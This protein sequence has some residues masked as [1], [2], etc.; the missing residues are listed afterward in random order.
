MIRESSVTKLLRD[1]RAEIARPTRPETPRDMRPVGGSARGLLDLV[2][3][4]R[5]GGNNG[6]T[7]SGNGNAGDINI[8]KGAGTVAVTHASGLPLLAPL[9]SARLAPLYSSTDASSLSHAPPPVGNAASAQRRTATANSAHSSAM[10]DGAPTTS[11]MLGAAAAAGAVGATATTTANSNSSAAA[12]ATTFNVR[13]PPTTKPAKPPTQ[14]RTTTAT[15]TAVATVA[16]AGGAPPQSALVTRRRAKMPSSTRSGE[17]S[18]TSSLAGDGDVAPYDD[19]SGNHANGTVG[20]AKRVSSQRASLASNNFNNNNNN[21]NNNNIDDGD[22][23]EDGGTQQQQHQHQPPSAGAVPAEKYKVLIAQMDAADAPTRAR[24][25]AEILAVL[26]QLGTGAGASSCANDDDDEAAFFSADDDVASFDCDKLRTK[27]LEVALELFRDNGLDDDDDDVDDD[28]HH[29][30]RDHDDPDRGG[31]PPRRPGWVAAKEARLIDT[32]LRYIESR[33]VGTV[34]CTVALSCIKSA[35]E[36]RE[37]V[38]SIFS[39]GGIRVM[40]HVL[41]SAVAILTSTSMSAPASQQ[42]QSHSPILILSVAMALQTLGFLSEKYS[43]QIIRGG[44]CAPC[45]H[46]AP[47]VVDDDRAA[48]ALCS[49]VAKLSADDHDAVHAWR[50]C[51]HGAL[52]QRLGRCVL[53][54]WQRVRAGKAK[55]TGCTLVS[56]GMLA[57]A[58]LIADGGTPL[59]QV[60]GD[61]PLLVALCEE[62]DDMACRTNPLAAD[63]NEELVNALRLISGISVNAAGGH[64]LAQHPSL[65]ELISDLL[66]DLEPDSPT[67]QQVLLLSL[68]CVSN[69][70]FYCFQPSLST[71]S[72]SHC[73]A[74]SSGSDN[75]GSGMMGGRRDYATPDDDDEISDSISLLW[76]DTLLPSLLGILFNDASPTEALVEATRALGNVSRTLAGCSACRAHRID[77]VV[78]ALL[79]HADARIVYNCLGVVTNLSAIA[80]DQNTPRKA[81]PW[82]PTAQSQVCELA[83]SKSDFAAYPEVAELA[84]A[85]RSNMALL[86]E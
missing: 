71:S 74:G 15:A 24:A 67:G 30:Q 77:E 73:R 1:A 35:S 32:A 84:N 33:A 6:G 68:V 82:L 56:R 17:N 86:V 29:H 16:L 44:I 20:A 59:D 78:C 28:H 42:Q 69:L 61:S 4:G 31:A 72:S 5:A 50:E 75:N 54:R 51:A 39:S 66:T 10:P 2:R 21:N 80:I 83:E 81:L 46:V 38:P 8:N 57:V 26:Q 36:I 60:A 41:D 40:K 34:D 22:D 37:C 58:L 27:A 79:I 13:P 12:T 63:D 9:T 19:A 11:P 85:A 64:M 65:K 18:E 45:V 70:T 55:V 62:F 14:L 76:L 53:L 47:F 25:A 52:A 7:G 23:D 49:L 3:A 43:S 48:A